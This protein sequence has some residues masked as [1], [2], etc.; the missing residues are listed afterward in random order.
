MLEESARRLKRVLKLRRFLGVPLDI[1]GCLSIRLCQDRALM[2]STW[3]PSSFREVGFGTTNQEEGM[4]FMGF[5]LHVEA[6][7]A[8]EVAKSV[9]YAT[10]PRILNL[11]KAGLLPRPKGEEA[12]AWLGSC[13]RLPASTTKGVDPLAVLRV[14]SYANL[15]LIPGNGAITIGRSPQEAL[16]LFGLLEGAFK[17][18][19]IGSLS[20]TQRKTSETCRG[21][22]DG[23]FVSE[24]PWALFGKEHKS[25]IEE[26]MV[27]NREAFLGFK[28]LTHFGVVFQVDE[29]ADGTPRRLGVRFTKGGV[30]LMNPE[31]ARGHKEILRGKF[32]ILE[33]IF[34]GKTPL[35]TVIRHGRIEGIGPSW[36]LVDSRLEAINL[37][38]KTVKA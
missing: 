28:G 32:P 34:A 6:Y 19:V 17:E 29:V 4:G 18:A 8:I 10:T 24:F 36:P 30:E 33:A 27:A 22:N 38:L 3:D 15:C 35:I 37:F 7:R 14:L 23:L 21:L 13:P 31:E 16:W 20:D 25:F 1:E 26:R 12:L 2:A 9:F 11:L 5:S